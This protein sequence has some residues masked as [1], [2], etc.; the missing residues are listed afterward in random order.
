[1]IDTEA[2]RKKV[3]NTAFNGE[4][5]TSLHMHKEWTWVPLEKIATIY[6]GRAYKQTELLTKK[7]GNT[8]VLRVGNLFTNNDWYYSDL[9]LDDNKYCDNGDLI[10][11]W[12]AS[13]GP[14]IWNGGK[15]IYHYHIW[16]I[17]HDDSI[18]RRF[19]Y[20]FLMADT[21]ALKESAHGVAMVHITK[22]RMENTLVP[23]PTIAEQEEIVNIIDAFFS[24]L[25]HI[26][27]L[28]QQYANNISS[29]NKKILD[30]A[31][32]GKLVPQDPNDEPASVLLKKI[33]EE[34]QKLIK[35]GKIKKQK[36]LPAITEDAIPY[37]IPESWEWV[38]M[39]S[40]CAK[41]TSG[42]TP[43]GGSKSNAYVEEGFPLFREQ[44]VYNDG[45]RKKGMVYITE[46]LLN[47]RA[48]S[49]VVANDIL[50][51]ITGG[52]IGRCAL[53]PSD[54]DRGSI[55]QHILII[56]NVN[57]ALK[58]YIHMCICSPYFQQQIMGN[59]V[60]DKDGFSAGRCKNVLV[61]VPPIPEQKR[62]V[63][64]VNLMLEQIA[65]LN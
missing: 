47:T 38:R 40:I 28:Q 6:N 4:L 54:F 44:N 30:L 3:L 32:R 24:E 21:Q 5:T 17:E 35:E 37:D 55:N 60:G 50:L 65:S 7:K 1:M 58:E 43:A 13:F 20:Y 14:F 16:K 23:V 51:N 10:Y 31:V 15:V 57:P 9:E 64:S 22:A 42:S 52:S 61:P 63:H 2:L 27:D 59:V 56:R 34:K 25:Q 48:N 46:A 26:D 39:D 12:S 62:I 41:I 18:D 8:P 45:I 19:L 49:T 53:V 36:A 29:L 11:A 33:A